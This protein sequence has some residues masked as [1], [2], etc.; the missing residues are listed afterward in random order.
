M[1]WGDAEVCSA[2]PKGYA[3]QSIDERRFRQGNKLNE[4][5]EK[6]NKSPYYEPVAECLT[7]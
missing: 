4:F 5:N 6:I 1:I 2:E 7:S 3:P